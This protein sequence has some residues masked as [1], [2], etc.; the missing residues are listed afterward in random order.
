MFIGKY[1]FPALSC[2]FLLGFAGCSKTDT[3]SADRDKIEQAYKYYAEKS[4][5][6]PGTVSSAKHKLKLGIIFLKTGDYGKAVSEFVAVI[7]IDPRI[8]EAHYNLAYAYQMLGNDD[9]AINEYKNAITVQPDYSEAYNNLGLLMV[10]KGYVKE[11]I[12]Y[13]KKSQ[14]NDPDFVPAYYNLGAVYLSKV[15]DNDMALDYF[16]RYLDAAPSGEKSEEAIK[17]VEF[18]KP[19][20]AGRKVDTAD[21]YYKRG[22]AALEKNDV[23]TAV[24]EFQKSIKDN[25]RNPHPYRELGL[26]YQDKMRDNDKALSYFEQYLEMNYKGGDAAEIMRRVSYLRKK[27]KEPEPQPLPGKIEQGKTEVAA[28]SEERGSVRSGDQELAEIRKKAMEYYKSG[29]YDKSAEA[30]KS[31]L[32]LEPDSAE[33][34][35]FLGVVCLKAGN[36]TEAKQYFTRALEISPAD[37]NSIEGLITAEKNSGNPEAAAA[38]LLKSDRKNEAA[39]IYRET[40][41]DFA[42]KKKYSEA[43]NNFEQAEKLNPALDLRQEKNDA[44]RRNAKAKLA[45][46]DVKGARKM[47][48]YLKAN[49]VTGEDIHILNGEILLAEKDFAAAASE[50]EKAYSVSKKPELKKL[51]AGALAARCRQ[52][53]SKGDLPG[54]EKTAG[55]IIEY[56]PSAY[57]VI[58]EIAEAYQAKGEDDESAYRCFKLYAERYPSS[59]YSKKAKD[60]I[61][62]YENKKGERESYRKK[63]LTVDEGAAQHYNL[64]VTYTKQTDYNRAIEEYKKAIQTDPSFTVAHY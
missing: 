42:R 34:T 23:K 28:A 51:T 63:M 40:G 26:I 45:S 61:L 35:S 18:L 46:G 27:E 21:L 49:G 1:I 38:L 52:L 9:N 59:K 2:I 64:A 19:G 48:E 16:M 32:M 54:A 37:K 4:K 53:I 56:D 8:A 30:Y 6:N 20:T 41:L 15:K 3:A 57:E 55:K 36:Y 39:D 47:L 33:L 22:L 44:A 50:F 5:E 7:D 12:Y 31:A 29:D 25:P 24:S 58:G 43:M 62:D 60:F 11:G 17:Y 10:K 13:L 14:E